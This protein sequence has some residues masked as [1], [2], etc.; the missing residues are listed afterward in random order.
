[1]SYH[2]SLPTT[3]CVSR[4]FLYSKRTAICNHLCNAT[5]CHDL[6]AVGPKYICQWASTNIENIVPTPEIC[7]RSFSDLIH[8]HD[9]ISLLFPGLPHVLKNLENYGCPGMSWKSPGTT[10]FFRLSWNSGILIKM[11]WKNNGMPLVHEI[12]FSM[13]VFQWPVS[14]LSS[15]F[16]HY[17]GP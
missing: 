9:F 13:E 16:M 1:M 7:S 5:T 15:C 12:W 3:F 6:W 17:T 2:F 11:S 4:C 8:C 10:Q 14:Y